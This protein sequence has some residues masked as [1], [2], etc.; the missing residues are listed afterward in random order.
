[1]DQLLK[2]IVAYIDQKGAVTSWKDTRPGPAPTED[3]RFR[4]CPYFA[5]LTCRYPK[6]GRVRIKTSEVVVAFEKMDLAA[7]SAS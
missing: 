6:G 3:A 2:M 4:N 1:M 5:V 7:S